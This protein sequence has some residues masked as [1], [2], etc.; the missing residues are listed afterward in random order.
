MRPELTSVSLRTA[1]FGFLPLVSVTIV[2]TVILGHGDYAVA[3]HGRPD[4]SVG[5]G[6]LYRVKG[7]NLYRGTP[8]RMSHSRV[9][10]LPT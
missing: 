2:V 8:E 1:V 5:P 3:E 6:R 10:E 7:P 9:P 4:G